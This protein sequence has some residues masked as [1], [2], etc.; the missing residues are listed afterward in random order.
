MSRLFEALNKSKG[1]IA[2]L[3]LGLLGGD[4]P[5]APRTGPRKPADAPDGKQVQLAEP[6]ASNSESTGTTADAHPAAESSDHEPEPFSEDSGE[7]NV[8]RDIPTIPQVGEAVLEGHP[9]RSAHSD[10][11][12]GQPSVISAPDDIYPN[13]NESG[14]LDIPIRAVTVRLQADTPLL[15]FDKKGNAVEAEQYRLIRT[16]LRQQPGQPQLL[17]VSSAQP[18]D[19]KT[20]TSINLAAALALNEE[21]Q[22]LLVDTD[23]RRPSIAEMLGVPTTPGVME[24]LAGL[25]SFD[26]TVTR[27][28]PFSNFYLLPAGQGLG[29][30]TE[31]LSSPRWKELCT[32]IRT[33]VTYAVF[34]G[35]PV[36]SVADY[37]LLEEALDGVLLVVRTD[38]TNRFLLKGALDA[39]SREKLIGAVVNSHRNSVLQGQRIDYR[40]YGYSTMEGEDVSE[41]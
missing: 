34:D 15:P 38:H 1:E 10:R 32:H 27:L 36:D 2:E 13:G 20:V 26:Q 30:P 39:I 12:E 6:R 7:V 37:R 35:P 14:R 24:V 28:R 19:G 31:L 17:L 29:N 4:S 5:E 22:V 40:Y 16:K 33:R 25:S 41:S 9:A 3:T 11:Q 18:A 21:A 8:S 23:L